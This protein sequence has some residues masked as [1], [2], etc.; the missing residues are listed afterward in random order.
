[1][2]EARVAVVIPCFNEGA[3]L[4]EAAASVLGEAGVAERVVVDDGS[5]S[6][7]TRTI[8]GELGR[9]GFGVIRQEN[10]GPS[11]ALMAGV[12]ATSAP[13]VFRL[14]SDDLLEPGALDA[15]ADALDAHPEAAAAWGDLQTFGLIDMRMPSNPVLDP[16]H[17]TFANLLPSCSLYR[18]T[19]L[20][21]VGGW[22]FRGGIDDWDL[23]MSFAESGYGGVYVPRV[24]Y[25]Y[26]RER[27]G[28]FADAVSRYETDYD[29]LRRERHPRL[30]AAR[31][32]NRA[33]SPAPRPLRVLLPIVDRLPFLPRLQKVWLAQ[34]ATYLFW[35]AGPR[36]TLR[37]VRRGVAIRVGSR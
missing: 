33:K 34:L 22:Q 15:L 25:R 1:V 14:D 3:P 4:R 29:E 19:A 32:A 9:Q 2:S 26:R 6:E 36:F 5:T 27:E 24:V 18:R 20:L 10:K 17:L 7:L 23:W 28:L 13:F 11:P 8:L 21:A 16:W 30:F 37:L 35:T 31:A 12:A